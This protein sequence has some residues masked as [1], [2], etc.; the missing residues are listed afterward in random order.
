MKDLPASRQFTV[1]NKMDINPETFSALPP[2]E[3]DRLMREWL[4]EFSRDELLVIKWMIEQ[5]RKR[6]NKHGV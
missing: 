5:E 4:G 1:Q 6:N 2:A 3:Q